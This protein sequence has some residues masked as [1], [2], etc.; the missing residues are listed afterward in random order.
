MVSNDRA[1]TPEDSLLVQTIKMM[2]SLSD[3]ENFVSLVMGPKNQKTDHAG[4]V[5]ISRFG[6]TIFWQFYCFK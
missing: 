4:M 6:L 2:H 1:R 3:I 5:K